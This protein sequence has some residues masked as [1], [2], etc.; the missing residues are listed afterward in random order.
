MGVGVT[1]RK[2][3]PIPGTE[4]LGCSGLGLQSVVQKDV[5]SAKVQKLG[6]T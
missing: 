3:L 2:D 1:H 5:L 6:K 4:V